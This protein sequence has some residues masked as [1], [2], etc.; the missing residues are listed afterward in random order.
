MCFGG[1]APGH[2]R[3]RQRVV[4]CQL[5]FPFSGCDI[6]VSRRWNGL[7]RAPADARTPR[8]P[9]YKDCYSDCCPMQYNGLMLDPKQ[10]TAIRKKLGVSQE[11]MARMV[12]VSFV[13]VNR[14]EGGHSSPTGPTLDLYT[15][16]AGALNSGFS[17]AIILKAAASD[18][19]SFLYSLF[20]MAY[21][22]ARR[23]A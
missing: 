10:L 2:L 9:I 7:L 1:P 11:Q 3:K 16:L 12:G 20:R 17:P 18:R 6:P 21:G 22:S 13:S 14:W 8:R 23:S 5:L 19:G 4:R 15:A